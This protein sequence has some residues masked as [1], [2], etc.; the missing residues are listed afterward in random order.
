MFWVGVNDFFWGVGGGRN[1]TQEILIL[2]KISCILI[3][4]LTN[5]SFFF[6]EN[7]II[8]LIQTNNT[9]IGTMVPNR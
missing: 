1:K 3:S 4:Y 5:L 2:G 9:M 6:F 8:L 7:K